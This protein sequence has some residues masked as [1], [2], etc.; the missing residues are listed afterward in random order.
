MEAAALEKANWY[1]E[2]VRITSCAEAA[3]TV[4][5]CFPVEESTANW[6]R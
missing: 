2:L 5:F 3:F 1:T 4:H 6:Q